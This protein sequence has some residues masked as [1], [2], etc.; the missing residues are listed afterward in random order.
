[1][2][3]GTY[4]RCGQAFAQTT[5]ALIQAVQIF[6]RGPANR[7]HCVD[8]IPALAYLGNSSLPFSLY[9]FHLSGVSAKELASS[10]S[11]PLAWVEERLEAVRL[12]L[13][14]QIRISLESKSVEPSTGAL[15][16]DAA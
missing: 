15:I 7:V 16:A 5:F 14:F 12:C 10:H 8:M 13:K 11:L 9:D 4:V 6:L 2:H 1:V 3:H